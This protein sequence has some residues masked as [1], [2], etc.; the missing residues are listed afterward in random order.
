M[1]S[2]MNDNLQASKRRLS[3]FPYLQKE[4]S[5]LCAAI[6]VKHMKNNSGFCLVKSL[7]L[8]LSG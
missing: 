4:A 8:I 6:R 2:D 3:L 7:A 5:L 1:L